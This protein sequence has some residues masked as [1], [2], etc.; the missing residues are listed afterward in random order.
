[1]VKHELSGCFSFFPHFKDAGGS[2]KIVVV[3]VAVRITCPE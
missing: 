2:T 3:V 1:M